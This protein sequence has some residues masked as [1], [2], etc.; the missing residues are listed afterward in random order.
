LQYL[1]ADLI[2]GCMHSDVNMCSWFHL[3]CC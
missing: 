2:Y 3:L 1:I